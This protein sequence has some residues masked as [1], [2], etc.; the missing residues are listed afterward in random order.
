MN[1]SSTNI[2]S[3]SVI[4]EQTSTNSNIRDKDSILQQWKKINELVKGYNSLIMINGQLS[5]KIQ[6][7]TERKVLDY[8]FYPFKI[9]NLIDDFRPNN[10]VNGYD[11][12]VNWRTVRVR[13]GYVYQ[14]NYN[15][16][17]AYVNGT[18]RMEGI[19]CQ[20]SYFNTSSY[21]STIDF[22]VPTGSSQY[23]FWI[24]QSGSHSVSSS[25]FYICCGNYPQSASITNPLPWTS[26]PT[27]SAT[28]WLIGWA[29]TNSSGSINNMLTHNVLRSD[30]FV[31]QFISMSVCTNNTL[32]DYYLP[33][34]VSGSI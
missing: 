31:H 8:G 19:A 10:G 24:N 15:S 7:I 6:E 13:G 27:A 32:V 20:Y 4:H 33:A 1:L 16:A 18:D 25:N 23:Y 26:F 2:T 29:D 12:T 34:Y 14:G 3:L 17:S 21:D 30:V 5:R 22:V 9:Y 11:N 28:N